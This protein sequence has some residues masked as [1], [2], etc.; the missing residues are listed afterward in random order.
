MP[1]RDQFDENS[2]FSLQRVT[3]LKYRTLV[4]LRA[5]FS[6]SR[7]LRAGSW[8]RLR[9]LPQP[10]GRRCRQTGFKKTTNTSQVTTNK[11]VVA[12]AVLI[13]I[14]STITLQHQ[15]GLSAVQEVLNIQYKAPSIQ[16]SEQRIHV[17]ICN[18]S[19]SDLLRYV[20]EGIPHFR[21]DTPLARLV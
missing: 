1:F 12:F 6:V 4:L 11:D 19:L 14:S 3:C 21:R 8:W 2:L 20:F 17:H 13:Q 5:V 18:P 9:L 7:E 16:H 15:L 10:P